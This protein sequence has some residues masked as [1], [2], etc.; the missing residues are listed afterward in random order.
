MTNYI[1][2]ML[3]FFLSASCVLGTVPHGSVHLVNIS[4]I[5]D[6]AKANASDAKFIAQS[7]ANL[8]SYVPWN[9]PNYG[10]MTSELFPLEPKTLGGV[11]STL[12]NLLQ[13]VNSNPG[14]PASVVNHTKRDIADLNNASPPMG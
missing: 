12:D 1:L 10:P 8:T 6:T 13:F 9:I 2:L 11:T 3:V 5:I 7:N 14:I 4:W